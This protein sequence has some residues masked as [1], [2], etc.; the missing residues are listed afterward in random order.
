LIAAIAERQRGRVAREQLLAA[1]A[2]SSAIDRR[3]RSGALEPVH[4]GVYALPH[5]S[6]VP[7]AMETGALLACGD[8]AALSHHSA[9]TLWHLRPG[10]ARPVHVTIPTGRSGAKPSGVKLHRSRILTPAD[11]RL[12]DGLPVTSPARTM[13]DVAANLPDRDV[14]RL[15]YEALFARRIVTLQEINATLRRA[16][17]H[18]GRKRLTRVASVDVRFTSTDSPPEEALHRM[19]RAAGL[20]EPRTQVQVLDY[21]LDF[22][23][24]ELGLAVEVDAYGTHGSPARFESDRHKDARLLTEMGIIVIRITRAMI[25][26]RPLE[27]LAIVTRAI[28]QQEAAVRSGRSRSR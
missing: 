14:E 24:P 1:G 15:L 4:F 22:F 10:E 28:D 9:A 6:D 3:L 5:T 2:T 27:A 16:G 19:I 13:L 8:G 18:P 12:R 26:Q 11:I 25:E 21:V 23:W 20:P 7:L 17:G